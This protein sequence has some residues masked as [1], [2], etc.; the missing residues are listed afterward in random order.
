MIGQREAPL[1]VLDNTSVIHKESSSCSELSDSD[2]EDGQF[3]GEY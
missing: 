3:E 2:R 1:A